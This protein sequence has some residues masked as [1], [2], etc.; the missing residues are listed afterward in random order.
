MKLPLTS[1]RPW[2]LAIAA[3]C[4][5]ALSGAASADQGSTSNP[6]CL[7]DHERCWQ[8]KGAEYWHWQTVKL[9]KKV[10]RLEDRLTN[11]RRLATT[12]TVDYAYRLAA[13]SFGVPYS[14]IRAV[15]ACESGHD[16]S[17]KNSSSTASGVM[18]F[19]DSTWDRTPFAGFSV[20][21]PIANVLAG[22]WL[23]RHDGGSWREWA[24][25][26]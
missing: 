14:E 9:E 21:D 5:L 11:Q 12:G 2:R 7:A 16:P 15:G 8:D 18:Q 25:K 4:A 10:Q 23:W 19:L 1:R 6:Y 3:L 17:A 26:P 20:F 24:C 13:A 22:G